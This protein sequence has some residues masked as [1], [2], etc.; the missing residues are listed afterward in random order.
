MSAFPV[1]PRSSFLLWCQSHAPIFIAEA[2]TIGL[3]AAQAEQFAARTLAAQEA[4]TAYDT[5]R[6][7]ARSAHQKML[8]ALAEL[9]FDAGLAVQSIRARA[10]GS[11]NPV[12]VYA[13]AKIDPPSKPSPSEPPAQPKTLRVALDASSGALTLRWK[14]ANPAGTQGTSYIIRRR[15]PGENGWTILGVAGKKRFVDN[16]LVAGT[17]QAEYIVQGLRSGTAGPPSQIFLVTFGLSPAGARTARLGSLLAPEGAA[18]RPDGGMPH[19]PPM[20]ARA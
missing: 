7:A 13:A 5:A 18:L 9:R 17:P 12:A 3:T 2:T 20:P 10:A 16:S 1:S 11:D 8:D 6:Q 4:R 15:L 19:G 14:A